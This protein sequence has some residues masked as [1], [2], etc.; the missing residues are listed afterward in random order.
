MGLST[1]PYLIR[2]IHE[3]CTDSGYRAYIAVS[4]DS[5]TVVPREFVRGGEI[6]LNVSPAATNRLHI[7]N[8]LIEF[9]ARF[10]GVARAVS[11]PIDNVSAIY[12]QETG[13]GM[14]FE[15]P[16]PLALE[17]GQ[18]AEDAPDSPVAAGPGGAPQAD[19]TSAPPARRAGGRPKLRAVP[20]PS[21]AS[22]EAHDNLTDAGARKSP[23]DGAV[24]E[25]GEGR[26][27][28]AVAAERKSTVTPL[29]AEDAKAPSVATEVPGADA[30]LAG[31]PKGGGD[32][33]GSAGKPASRRRKAATRAKPAPTAAAS[34]SV[35]PQE[36]ESSR[37]D[38]ASGEAASGEAAPAE[39]SAEASKAP[40][41]RA[42]RARKPK[43]EAPPAATVSPPVD[44]P[45]PPPRRGPPKL[46][47]VK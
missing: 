39:T 42:S 1:K 30:R 8:E 44:E 23:A 14:A 36:S 13:Q 35:T 28:P 17:P 21:E 7:G 33:A 11:I 4:V 31:D 47:R 2:A 3:W 29:V 46:T 40:R 19:E 22:R 24:P 10:G 12:A 38:T 16:K 20:S 34:E 25:A 26:A 18:G 41:A 27:D 6:V 5:R 9:E 45:P 15:V 37:G 32:D 43:A